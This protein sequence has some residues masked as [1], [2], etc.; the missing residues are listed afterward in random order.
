MELGL[1]FRVRVMELGLGF[2]AR[3]MEIGLSYSLGLGF[4]VC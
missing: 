3:V 1:G 4:R 2:R